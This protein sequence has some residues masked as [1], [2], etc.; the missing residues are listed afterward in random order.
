MPKRWFGAIVL[1][2]GLG[3][4]TA[5]E[6]ATQ[7]A[8][9][10]ITISRETTY[11]LGPVA[12]DGTIHYMTALNERFRQGITRENNAAVLLMQ[13]FG[14]AYVNEAVLR[15][16][17]DELGIAELPAEGK[18]FLDFIGFEREFSQS[19]RQSDDSRNLTDL[20]SKAMAGPWKPG[21][22]PE[23][24]AWLEKN[25]E[26]LA[27]I[28]AASKRSRYYMPLVS[29]SDP[30]RMHDFALPR[31]SLLRDASRALMARAMR[32]AGAGDM[33]GAAADLLAVHRLARLTGGNPLLIERLVAVAMESLACKADQALAIRGKWTAVQARNMLKELEGLKPVA[34][35]AE[36]IDI[37]E[38]C[39]LLDCLMLCAREGFGRLAAIGVDGAKELESLDARQLDWDLILRQFNSWYDRI[40]KAGRC[41]T[42]S[43]R[44]AELEQ[45]D[46]D[47]R[48]F[49]QDFT[50]KL[51]EKYSSPEQMISWAGKAI[52]DGK[53]STRR[54]VSQTIGNLLLTVLMPSL[55]RGFVMYDRGT[56]QMDLARLAVALAAY[57]A[58][59]GTYP[60]RL[61]ELSPGLLKQVPKDRFND[62]DLVYKREGK[63][64]LLYSVSENLTDDGGKDDPNE[65]DIVVRAE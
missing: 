17:L 48:A 50:A 31:L 8:K 52:A 64:Y 22:Y 26:S 5:G 4:L 29:A 2:A 47:F 20:R 49:S 21:D 14:P 6:P 63:G 34:D 28:V 24:A 56:T 11:L 43:Q 54:E 55:K 37:G 9:V 32:K 44:Q 51:L 12:K 58:E 62:K 19:A 7:P 13:A 15:K 45:V 25:T 59:K 40:V 18:Y 57:K 38:R 30:P 53:D 42:H 61:A 16:T 23:I 3:V 41:P 35:M 65:G 33:E 46:K 39:F 36:A 27:L 10:K 1:V 60:E